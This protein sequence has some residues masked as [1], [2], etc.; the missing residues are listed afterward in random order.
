MDKLTITLR[1]VI[2]KNNDKIKY[3]IVKIENNTYNY[4]NIITIA[5]EINNICMSV[6]GGYLKDLYLDEKTN[7]IILL[8]Y[9]NLIQMND[10]IKRYGVFF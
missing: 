7:T 3:H 9:S 10:I 6:N 1:K 5:E 4:N 2:D 8:I